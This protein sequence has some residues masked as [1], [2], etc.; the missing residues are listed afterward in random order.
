MTKLKV[1][2]GLW[3]DYKNA[4][5]ETSKSSELDYYTDVFSPW[6]TKQKLKIGREVEWDVWGKVYSNLFYSAAWNTSETITWVWFKPKMIQFNVLYDGGT[7]SARSTGIYND[8]LWINKCIFVRDGGAGSYTGTYSIVLRNS[9]SS[10]VS[11]GKVNSVD[12]DWFTL[13]FVNVWGWYD[14]AIVYTCFG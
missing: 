4:G 12:D 2:K 10:V 8:E 3:F 13:S 9:T 6:Q 5:L 11:N 14:R 7:M 1:D